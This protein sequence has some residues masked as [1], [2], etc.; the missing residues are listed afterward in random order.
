MRIHERLQYKMLA[1]LGYPDHLLDHLL[2]FLDKLVRMGPN[3]HAQ[4]TCPDFPVGAVSVASSMAPTRVQ[5]LLAE[6]KEIDAFIARK[7][8]ELSRPVLAISRNKVQLADE[9]DVLGGLRSV[10]TV[11]LSKSRAELPAAHRGP[12]QLS[13]AHASVLPA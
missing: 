4:M 10:E 3:H 11:S 13:T 8:T 2:G 7:L 1:C 6:G 5:K 9:R 12:Q